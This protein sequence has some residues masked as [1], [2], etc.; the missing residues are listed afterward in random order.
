MTSSSTQA[1]ALLDETAL[2]RLAGHLGVSRDG[3]H[4]LPQSLTQNA[5]ASY[6]AIDVVG[7]SR[8]LQI[9]GEPEIGQPL[10]SD[11][12]NQQYL[13]AF[14]PSDDAILRAFAERID[15][16]FLPRPQRNAPAIAVGNRH[17]EISLPAA[18]DAFESILSATG[19]NLASTVQLSATREMTTDA[20]IAARDGSNPTAPGHTRVSIRH[21]YHAGIWAAIRSGYRAGYNAEADHFIVNGSD[22]AAIAK[23]VEWV[24][25]AIRHAAGYTKFTTDTSRLFDL[26]ADSRHPSPWTES[27]I[28]DLFESRLT[29]DERSWALSAFSATFECEDR[30]YRF[31]DREIKRLAVKFVPQ[32]KTQRRTLRCDRGRQIRRA[33]RF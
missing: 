2:A 14:S 26:R 17:P 27:E 31:T 13:Y 25:E 21:L 8:L 18:F 5:R 28:D 29:P 9:G 15:R 20:E 4:I 7:Q 32:S 10:W 1:R 33:I 19:R 16:S 23:S 11:G 24:K 3:I 12:S 30:A 22:D 6:V